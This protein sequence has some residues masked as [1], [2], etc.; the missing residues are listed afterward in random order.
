LQKSI[1]GFGYCILKYDIDVEDSPLILDNHGE[2]Q[3]WWHKR[4]QMKF[5]TK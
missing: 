1:T 3:P 5:W 4:H 2:G